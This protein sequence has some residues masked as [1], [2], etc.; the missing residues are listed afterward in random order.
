MGRMWQWTGLNGKDIAV[1]R[2]KWERYGSGQ[3]LNGKDVAVDRV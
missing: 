2:F 3:G 1:N